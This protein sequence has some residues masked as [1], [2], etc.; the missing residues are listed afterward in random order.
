[1]IG[2]LL[3]ATASAQADRYE[4]GQRL[5]K[6]EKT[7]DLTKDVDAKQRAVAL[8]NQAVRSFFSFNFAA[9]GE[10]LDMA[11]H[12]LTSGDPPSSAVQWSDSLTFR[13]EHRLID[14]N[15]KQLEIQIKP[16]YLVADDVPKGASIRIK[17]SDQKP[18]EIS[19]TGLP[20]TCKLPLTGIGPGD[21]VLTIETLVAGK[22]LAIRQ[23]MVSCAK[24][25]AS[26]L[27]KLKKIAGS[28]D[29]N[30][31]I[32]QGT[33]RHLLTI[34]KD[35]ASGTVLET[36]IPAARLLREAEEVA[37]AIHEGKQHYV[38]NRSGQFW[39]RIP[40][41]KSLET[42]RVFIPEGLYPAKRVPLVFALHGAGGSENLFFDGY[43]DGIS[44]KL[45][46]ERGWIMVAPRAGGTL[47][48]G[49]TPNVVGILD[50]LA[51]RYPIDAKR[52]YMIG[53]SMGAGHV[54]AI[55]QQSPERFAG[56]AALGGGG[57]LRKPDSVKSLPF[58]VGV[59][60]NDFA[61]GSARGL[62]NA[63]KKAN[64]VRTE[65]KEYENVEHM[66]IVREAA[67]DVF[68]FWEGK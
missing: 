21:H 62:A 1:V 8:L 6:F 51:K 45:C 32:E 24:D 14:L 52:V 66:M 16:L 36:D 5:R 35:L 23:I 40:T 50:E 31:S 12:A 49:G 28:L 13:P 61:G 59:G 25:L 2:L 29:A 18:T 33:L 10:N 43:G 48:F 39:L 44:M 42:A 68:R 30:A 53:H 27:E 22:R 65:L 3:P 46:R 4:L 11:R 37:G 67:P 7:W 9:V 55:A 19:I 54:V 47:G 63:L 38:S 17:L 26:R 60:K 41:G 20:Q 15:S 56:V 58:F 57:A 34:T 64:T